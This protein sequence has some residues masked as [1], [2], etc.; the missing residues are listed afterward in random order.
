MSVRATAISVSALMIFVITACSSDSCCDPT[1]SKISEP[2]REFSIEYFESYGFK[3]AKEYDV[4]ELPA[5]S[6]AYMGYFAPPE[7]NSVQYELRMYP[8]QVTAIDKGISYADEV[9][10]ENAL[11]RSGD[12]RWPEGTTDRRAG[13]SSGGL[14]ARYGDFVVVG[15][16][17]IL[18]E[19][20]DSE[21]ALD[22]CAEL[23][24]ATGIGV[25][26]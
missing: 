11:V 26:G 25:E 20:R 19:G 24:W 5:A 16:T 3:T 23:L 17:I 18:C 10:G 6:S 9:T 2:E 12:T 21:Q 22:R 8:N 14:I 4:A 13:A 15:N 7:Q 1:F